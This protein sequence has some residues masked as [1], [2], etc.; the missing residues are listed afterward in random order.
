MYCKHC[1]TLIE[2]KQVKCNNCGEVIDEA[3]PFIG[4]DQDIPVAPVSTTGFDKKKIVISIA[5]VI[6]VLFGA[7]NLFGGVNSHSSPSAV[8][9][10]FIKAADQHNVD[11]MVQL[12]SPEYQLEGDEE[13]MERELEM[14]KM[15]LSNN[16]FDVKD[17]EIIDV[18]QDGDE[19]TV[20]YIITISEDGDEH[21]VD[22]ESFEVVK[23]GKKW[24]IDENL[25]N[26]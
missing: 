17:Y 15:E 6:V 20:H 4:S 10:G 7:Y 13:Y 14:L 1:G 2:N 21:E 12:I 26:F 16:D 5:V 8:V 3:L 19:A 9:K 22:E 24:Y 11:K 23:I 18:E 25:Y